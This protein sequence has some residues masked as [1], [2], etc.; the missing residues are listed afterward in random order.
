MKQKF[1]LIV[2]VIITECILISLGLWQLH[3]LSWKNHLVA[4][5]QELQSSP[6]KTI[7]NPNDLDLLV[8]FQPIIISGNWGGKIYK[9]PAK[10]YNGEMGQH[11]YIPLILTNDRPL[12]VRRG[13]ISKDNLESLNQTSMQLTLRG[14]IIDPFAKGWMRPENNLDNNE[15]YWPDLNAMANIYDLSAPYPYLFIEMPDT[16]SAFQHIPCCESLLR[17]PH[18]EYALTWFGLALTLMGIV[19]VY[20]KKNR[21]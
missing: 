15:W 1:W 10:V 9:F 8:R 14:T 19:F 11:I 2:C 21:R 13:W 5:F 7:S 12:M 6:P 16:E 17:N 3:R 18:L 4:E 20:A